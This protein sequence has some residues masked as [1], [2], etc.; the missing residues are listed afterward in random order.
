MGGRRTRAQAREGGKGH[1]KT[2]RKR[3]KKTAMLREQVSK[4]KRLGAPFRP[5][6]RPSRPSFALNPL[7][8]R[9]RKHCGPRGDR[10]RAVS[11]PIVGPPGAL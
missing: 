6:H 9:F 3:E 11:A 2:R 1:S 5:G 10:E 8:R 7:F 4:S